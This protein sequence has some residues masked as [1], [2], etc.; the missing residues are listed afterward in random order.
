MGTSW[1]PR[2]VR[3]VMFT[4]RS[5]AWIGTRRYYYH[6]MVIRNY[7]LDDEDSYVELLDWQPGLALI[8]ILYT[9][10]MVRMTG[11]QS[12]S[13][14]IIIITREVRPSPAEG[15]M[16]RVDLSRLD[17]SLDPGINLTKVITMRTPVQHFG[18]NPLEIFFYTFDIG[19]WHLF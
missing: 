5:T 18:I 6:A 10:V 12:S 17:N 4:V 13:M 9:Q 2:E 1:I 15:Q 8:V 11:G 16:E 3:T 19:Y 7:H 14:I